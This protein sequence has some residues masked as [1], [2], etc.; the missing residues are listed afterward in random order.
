MSKL[1]ND[2]KN[3]FNNLEFDSDRIQKQIMIKY[4]NHKKNKKITV[5]IISLLMV[6]L[7]GFGIVYAQEIGEVINDIFIRKTIKQNADGNSQEYKSIITNNNINIDLNYE[8]KERIGK[9]SLN[10]PTS[11]NDSDYQIFKYNDLEELLKVKI[12]KSK[13]IKRDSVYTRRFKKENGYLSF[14][15][16]NLFQDYSYRIPKQTIGNYNDNVLY[17]SLDMYTYI[18]S[19]DEHTMISF[20]ENE[21]SSEFNEIN[22]KSINTKGLYTK[23]KSGRFRGIYF[24]YDGITYKYR[25]RNNDID[26]EETFEKN[27]Q[28]FINSLYV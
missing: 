15:M 28:E 8:F 4:N 19:K 13:M 1:D 20:I 17:V 7:V 23:S 12:I 22:I 3:E 18:N 9:D 11:E 14:Q 27:V 6:T 10:G 26:D 21:F 5:S 24:T 2:F 25:I 16:V